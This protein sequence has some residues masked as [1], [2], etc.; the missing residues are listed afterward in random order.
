MMEQN[1]I[2]GPYCGSKPRD[3]LVDRQQWLVENMSD[4]D[5]G[6]EDE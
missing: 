4:E 2:V 5:E 6:E 1:G 3:I